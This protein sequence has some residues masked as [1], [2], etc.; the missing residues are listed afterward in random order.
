MSYSSHGLYTLFSVLLHFPPSS[1]SVLIST[2][3]GSS[4]NYANVLTDLRSI[5]GILR[6]LREKKES[7]FTIINYDEDRPDQRW[8]AC[9]K[10]GQALENVLSGLQPLLQFAKSW[11]A[12]GGDPL[13]LR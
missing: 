12:T 4:L 6:A 3:T 5:I 13:N 8:S 1:K 2:F 9:S 7:V 10:G 11:V